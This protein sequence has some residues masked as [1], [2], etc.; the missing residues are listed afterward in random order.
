V[1]LQASADADYF[2]KI[3]E[4]KLS[5]PEA[6]QVKKT[7]LAAYR[8]QYIGSGVSQP[9]FQKALGEMITEAQMQRIGAALQPIVS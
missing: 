1:Q 5:A 9:R 4:R 3:C 2:L 6:Q 8:W 7:V